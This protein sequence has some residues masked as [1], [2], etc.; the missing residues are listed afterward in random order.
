MCKNIRL[1]TYKIVPEDQKCQNIRLS[2]KISGSA[3]CKIVLGEQ[4]YTNIRLRVKISGSAHRPSLPREA[5]EAQ[6][7]GPSR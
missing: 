1:S 7:T 4:K 2:V 3:T 5:S 6:P